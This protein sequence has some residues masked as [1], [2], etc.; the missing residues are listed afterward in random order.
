M[1]F[2]MSNGI[3]YISVSNWLK[4][5]W[6]I[7]QL[8]GISY[9]SRSKGSQSRCMDQVVL[10]TFTDLL[11]SSTVFSVKQ[12]IHIQSSFT[13][14]SDPHEVHYFYLD[15]HALNVHSFQFTVC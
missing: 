5:T 7:G 3:W 10:L 12:H 8:E 2:Y 9:F 15:R 1:F 14:S 13:R 11:F 6:V 4:C